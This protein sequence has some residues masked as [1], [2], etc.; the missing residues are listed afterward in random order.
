MD[1]VPSTAMQR[2]F[3]PL[4]LLFVF[5]AN[6]FL[7]FLWSGFGPQFNSDHLGEGWNF[8][9]RDFAAS[10]TACFFSCHRRTSCATWEGF[11][12]VF[13]R[14]TTWTQ[15]EFDASLGYPG[16]GPPERQMTL[17]S[18]NIGSIMTDVSWKTWNADVVCLQE[19]RVGRNNHRTASKAFHSVGFTP[20]FSDLLPGI[21]HGSNTT[22]TPCGGTLIA[23]GSAYL[24]NFE[25]QQDATGIYE[26]IFKTKR[27]VA[28][29]LQVTAKK[30]ALVISVYARTSASQDTKI[31]AENNDLFEDILSFVAQFGS[32]PVLI[33]GDFQAPPDSYPAFAAALSFQS[34]HDPIVTVDANGDV[35]RPITF[36]NDSTFAGPGEGCTSIDSILL[37][38][39]AFAALQSAEVVGTFGKQHR[40]IKLVFNWESINQIGHHILKTAPFILE[41]CEGPG[42]QTPKISWECSYKNDFDA[43]SSSD[44]KW[45]VVNDFLQHTLIAKGASWGDGPRER[46][47]KPTFVSKIIAPKQMASHCAA[48][49]HGLQLARLI[50]RLS[51][52]FIRLSKPE[53]SAQDEF[54]TFSTASKVRS[55]LHRLRSPVCW[56]HH[57]IPSLVEVFYAKSWAEQSLKSHELA[58][59]LKR[60]QNWQDRIRRSASH[61]C[62]Y[63]FH[64]LKNKQQDEPAN[65]VVDQDQ[66]IIYQPDQALSYLNSEWDQVYSAN[67]LRHHPLKM[68]DT[69]WPYIHDQRLEVELPKISGID[70]FNILQK[71]KT[72]AAPGL[73]GWRT[74][75]LQ[76]FSASELQPCADCFDA[77]E[78]SNL[79]LP[80]SLVCAK[81]VILNKP[82]PA[83]PLNKRLITILPALLLAYTGARFAQLQDWQKA[84]MP[85]SILGGIKGRH[86]SDLFNQLR[87]DIDE[88]KHQNDALIGIKIDKAKAFDRIIPHFVAALF[89]AFGLPT[90]FVSFFV[91]IYDG[92]HRHLS[93][94]NW[95]SPV[96]TTAPNGVCQGCSLSLLDMNA[97]TRFGVTF[98]TTSLKFS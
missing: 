68:L 69:V 60:I 86:M 12:R 56:V 5:D 15:C 41:E 73:D 14:L 81:Q 62:A 66:N 96:S 51:E 84:I 18:A 67:V 53:G 91:K 42:N 50:G 49:F 59:K 24:K 32:I 4:P 70:L 39:I 75:E 80:K 23:G 27:V 92:L 30:R 26:R 79:P 97:Y 36:S 34:W 82:G 90:G 88:A 8:Q 29:W 76:R 43:V 33:A 95:T 19:T 38:D 83:A 58:V 77:I 46:A 98:S 57:R 89:L 55:Q 65:L 17:V 9:P 71:R 13:Q 61:G 21:W 52:L 16:E 63:I 1:F 45:A 25:I 85:S 72:N 87:L 35:V 47:G 37:N 11:G 78:S 31:H 54:I 74:T 40:P 10:K 2:A 94:R 6:L 7:G 22:K 44:D 28:A 93:Y 64:H 3:G 20:C 48:N